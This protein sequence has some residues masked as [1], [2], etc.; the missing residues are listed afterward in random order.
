[1]HFFLIAIAFGTAFFCSP[2]VT[3]QQD[4][5]FSDSSFSEYNNEENSIFSDPNV[6]LV[7]SN[8]GFKDNG[9]QAFEGSTLSSMKQSD[10]EEPILAS[11][12]CDNEKNNFDLNKLR[13]RD[14]ATGSCSDLPSD[15]SEPKEIEIIQTLLDQI[16]EFQNQPRVQ[17][18]FPYVNRLCCQGFA[19]YRIIIG[20]PNVWELVDDCVPALLN[21]PCLTRIEV[22]CEDFDPLT[23]Q[24]SVCIV[25]Y[26]NGAQ[27]YRPN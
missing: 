8:S 17:C 22:C 20:P 19:K 25:L 14:A 11:S 26:A 1:M 9:W 13:A 27:F 3:G 6:A 16:T 7:D 4:S 24:G 5:L 21:L 12:S 2:T 18:F 23:G 15:Q 10:F